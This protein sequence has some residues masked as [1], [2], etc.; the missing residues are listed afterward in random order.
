MSNLSDYIYNRF[1]LLFNK[2][3]NVMKKNFIEIEISIKHELNE[4]M[5]AIKMLENK[6]NIVELDQQLI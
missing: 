1:K 4:T 5:H 3:L 2:L 6:S